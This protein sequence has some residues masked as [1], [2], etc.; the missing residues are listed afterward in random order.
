MVWIVQSSPE[1]EV[2]DCSADTG[3]SCARVNLS[4]NLVHQV[5]ISLCF[6]GCVAK[7]QPKVRAGGGFGGNSK[8][9]RA[10]ERWWFTAESGVEMRKQEP[11]DWRRGNDGQRKRRKGGLR[12]DAMQCDATR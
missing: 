1:L 12:R 5:N 9:R 4:G 7:R 6:L 11:V 10:V 3:C 2:T 8:V